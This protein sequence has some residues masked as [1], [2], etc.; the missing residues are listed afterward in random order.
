M[1]RRPVIIIGNGAPAVIHSY[2]GKAFKCPFPIYTDPTL[3]CVLPS[4][5]WR[6]FRL[7]L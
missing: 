7:T 4:Q 6:Q 1:R 5:L 2:Q 3:E